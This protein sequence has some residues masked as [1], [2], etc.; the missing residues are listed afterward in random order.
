MSDVKKGTRMATL[1][2]MRRSFQVAGGADSRSLDEKLSQS[3]QAEMNGLPGM[4]CS[5]AGRL[6]SANVCARTT[7]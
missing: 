4:S 7:P 1:H 2:A 3:R 5:Q 6:S